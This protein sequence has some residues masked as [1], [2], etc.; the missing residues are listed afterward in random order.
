MQT[1]YQNNTFKLKNLPLEAIYVIDNWLP[2][3]MFTQFDNVLAKTNRWIFDNDVTYEDGETTEITWIMR[4]FK[5]WM[6]P[7]GDYV[8]FARPII[9]QMCSDFG[10]E[11]EQFD[12]AG[13]NGQTQGLQGTIHKDSF[14]PRNI[15]FLWHCNTEWD[16]SWGGSFR[17]YQRDTLDEGQ[18][19][20]SEELVKN[21][22]IAE[23]EYKPNRLIIVDGSMPHS[24]DA[25]NSSSGYAFRK[26]FVARG[27]VAKIVDK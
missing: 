1:I 8:E 25:P 5:K 14:R 24:A 3:N 21:Y 17:V 4:L 23:I 26:T 19:G 9:D 27:N 22:Q 18:R 10:I 7:A 2:E 20:F 12:F 13:I 16:S 6:K 15:T 11:F